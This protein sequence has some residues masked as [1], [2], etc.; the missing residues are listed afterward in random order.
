LVGEDEENA[1][2][3]VLCLGLGGTDIGRWD[4]LEEGNSEPE[5]NRKVPL[6]LH[7]D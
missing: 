7:P 1:R 5:Q 4:G 6:S 2:A 3:T